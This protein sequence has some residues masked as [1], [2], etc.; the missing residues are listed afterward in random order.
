[1][2]HL[3][4]FTAI[5][6]F[7][8]LSACYRRLD[9]EAYRTTPKMVINSAFSP[10]TVVM[11]SVSRTWFHT[12]SMPDVTLRNAKVELYIDGVFKEEMPWKAYTYWKPQFWLGEDLG[13]WITD[14]LYLS[15]TI[16]LP[17]QTVRIVA[18]TPE[19]GTAW[20]EDIVP[21]K[22]EI[23]DLTIRNNLEGGDVI[24]Y[25]ITFQDPPGQA[26]YY[27]LQIWGDDE[28][29]G[30]FLDFSVDPVFNRQQGALDEV[31]GSGLTNWRGRVFSDELFDGKRY[32]LQVREVVRLDMDRATR[33]HVR[34]YSLT[35]PYY[36]YLFSLQNIS[37]DD[38]SIMGGL[39]NIGLAE[40]VRIYS[41]V[42]GGTGIVGGCQ[43]VETLIDLKELIK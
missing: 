19:Y 30:A 22:V 2:R 7:L 31:F 41:N 27:S 36:Q 40:P 38:E 42:E 26:N 8:L 39:T 21:R 25:Q 5:L 6:S 15:N 14:T 16:P 29:L 24:F 34:L 43:W 9:L 37:D 35:E 12:E 18:T 10:D 4:Y 20:A 28:H 3:L 17:G 32:T 13:E 11:A 33:R 23:E 1:M